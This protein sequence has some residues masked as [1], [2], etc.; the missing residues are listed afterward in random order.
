MR[1]TH[2]IHYYDQGFVKQM[3]VKA[4]SPQEATITFF[5][6]KPFL[7]IYICNESVVGKDKSYKL[8]HDF[9]YKIIKP[10]EKELSDTK[11]IT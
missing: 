8:V 5:T 11:C 9:Q 7:S 6:I 1:T 2:T 10:I 3:D 4:K